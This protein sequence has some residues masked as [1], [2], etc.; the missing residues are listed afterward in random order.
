VREA[1]NVELDMFIMLDVSS[2]ML[3]VLPGTQT[4]K[5][6][7]VQGSVTQ[8]VQAPETAAIGIGL[9]YFPQEQEDSPGECSSSAD[10]GPLGGPC[11]TDICVASDEDGAGTAYNHIDG[12]DPVN[13]FD[14]DDCSAPG[15]SCAGFTGFCWAEVNPLTVTLLPTDPDLPLAVC[16]QDADCPS[17]DPPG[18][19]QVVP[20]MCA[21]LGFCS[22]APDVLCDQFVPCGA[23]QGDCLGFPNT[24][25]NR[26]KCEVEDY[27]TP[28][29]PI[30]LMG[31]RNQDIIDSLMAH[32]IGD[33]S[34]TPTG[35]ALEGALAQA[36]E[37]ADTHPGRQVVTVLA[38]D[39]VPTVCEDVAIPDVSAIAAA[40]REQAPAIE[41]FVI[42]VFSDLDL[43]QNADDAADAIANAGGTSE[44]FVINTAGDVAQE[45]LDSLNVIRDA[46]ISCDFQLPLDDD[47]V[48]FGRV[49]LK[50]S[51]GAGNQRQL[52][53]VDDVAGCADSNEDGWYYVTDD[54]ETPSQIVVCPDVCDLFAAGGVTADLQIGCATIVR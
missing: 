39:G 28:A 1:E 12:V 52:V 29:V 15:Q 4:T 10:C 11:S 32:N 24:C 53:N 3:D 40:A 9:G 16:S 21:P 25:I 48:D 30:S 54:G 34:L 8:F 42:G 51:D 33:F 2:S 26:T 44:A 20:G 49:N 22:Q 14:D 17:Y 46:S 13:C 5:W 7:A 45:F 50:I 35:P 36:K 38:T 18:N 41:T 27:S 47:S 31:G 6:T 37:W 19:G 43:M 23:G